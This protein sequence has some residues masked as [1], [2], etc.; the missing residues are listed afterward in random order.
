LAKKWHPFETV[1][2]WY[3]WCILDEGIVVY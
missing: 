3:T 1:D 2:T